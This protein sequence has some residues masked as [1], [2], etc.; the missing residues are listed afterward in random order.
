MSNH[1]GMEF[2]FQTTSRLAPSSSSD[3]SIKF[4]VGVQSLRG[5][6]H[7]SAKFLSSAVFFVSP[8]IPTTR[9]LI[10]VNFVTFVVKFRFKR[11]YI[12]NLNNSSETL[13]FLLLPR[14]VHLVRAKNI[15]QRSFSFRRENWNIRCNDGRSLGSRY[16][17]R[18]SRVR[19]CHRRNGTE[20]S[21][22]R[23][24]TFLASTRKLL[25][26]VSS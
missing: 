12:L 7:T 20:P 26:L 6:R 8:T 21:Q 13:L 24:F 19:N 22:S 23:P 16:N 10:R 17:Y 2:Y 5:R 4:Q 15:Y 18:Q 3:E 14:R 11:N 25:F 1:R 9:I